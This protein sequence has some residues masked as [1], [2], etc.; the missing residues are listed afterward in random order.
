MVAVPTPVVAVAAV[1]PVAVPLT[2]ELVSL[3]TKPVMVSVKVGL[4][5]PYRRLC[6]SA[7]TVRCA[8]VTL[9]ELPVV[10]KAL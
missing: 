5:A 8:L 2:T 9:T 7:V 3:L 4:A 1:L 6:P 10:L